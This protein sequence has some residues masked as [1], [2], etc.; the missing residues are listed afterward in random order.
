MF[1]GKDQPLQQFQTSRKKNPIALNQGRFG[2]IPERHGSSY[3][4]RELNM[5]GG[6]DFRGVMSNA[7]PYEALS[8]NS[9]NSGVGQDLL[10]QQDYDKIYNEEEGS[11]Y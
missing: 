2:V 1:T 9:L 6:D 10:N 4:K 7:D 3:N 5:F 8:A 11:N